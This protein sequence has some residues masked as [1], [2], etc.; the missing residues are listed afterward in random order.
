ML[1]T[2]PSDVDSLEGLGGGITW[3]W[4]PTLCT[5]LLPRFKER[6]SA[7]G[8]T[9]V[10]CDSIKAALTRAFDNWS[11]NSRYINFLDV[12][13][14]CEK[15]GAL[16][17]PPNGP[18]Q[19]GQKH[20]GCP[21]AEIWVTQLA[22]VASPQRRRAQTVGAAPSLD[23]MSED[24][25][26]VQEEQGGQQQL[27]GGSITAVATALSYLR[28]SSSFRFTNGE[29]PYTLSS[30]G[31]RV[32]GRH[33]VETISGRLAYAASGTVAGGLDLCWYLDSYFCSHFHGL[34]RHVGSPQTARVLV[35]VVATLLLVLGFGMLLFYAVRLVGAGG[36]GWMG[37]AGAAGAV[38]ADRDRDGQLSAAERA[39]A[40]VE[41]LSR[42]NPAAFALC[43]TLMIAPMAIAADIFAP[44]FDCFDFE[45]AS[46]ASAGLDPATSGL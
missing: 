22:S 35:F 30:S 25:Y 18:A 23:S 9:L 28:V 13:L 27:R 16:F 3:A 36:F 21:L 4:D 31:E 41:T 15:L 19:P 17:G 1:W 20:G 39:M 38:Q 37:G 5:A 46:S 34:K 29:R 10:S 14:E 45:A 2:M 43:V 6:S 8:S 26:L 33:I 40:V 42:W 32:Y 12:T 7:F 24:A 44:C 11:A